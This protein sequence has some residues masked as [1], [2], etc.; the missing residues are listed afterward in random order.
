[1]VIIAVVT[2]ICQD[3]R[4]SAWQ[5]TSCSCR[6]QGQCSCRAGGLYSDIEDSGIFH[7]IF[8]L[9]LRPPSP[10]HQVCRW[11]KKRLW[12]EDASFL[13]LPLAL[14]PVLV[15]RWHTSSLLATFH[16]PSLI[17]WS[18][19]DA[20]ELRNVVSA[21]WL[22]L[23]SNSAER[24]HESLMTNNSAIID[25][26]FEPIT[27][28]TSYQVLWGNTK[29]SYC[30]CSHGGWNIKGNWS[31]QGWEGKGPLFWYVFFPA[32][33]WLCVSIVTGADPSQHLVHWNWPCSCLTFLLNYNIFEVSTSIVLL[34]STEPGPSEE[35]SKCV[36][37][38][39]GGAVR[40][41]A[42]P[43]RK[44]ELQRQ[45][46][47]ILCDFAGVPSLLWASVFHSQ[48]AEKNTNFAGLLW[49]FSEIMNMYS[50]P[51]PVPVWFLGIWRTVSLSSWSTVLAV[52]F[53]QMPFVWSREFPSISSLVSVFVRKRYWILS[54]GFLVSSRDIHIAFVLYA[55]WGVWHI[56][57][58]SGCEI[59][60]VLL[61]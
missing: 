60:F 58:F 15:L 50:A 45:W 31:P 38:R 56:H 36:N 40:C 59:N 30:S 23:C 48:N 28:S 27:C 13:T 26:Y 55:I 44:H 47:L 21:W 17:I 10:V 2:N 43:Y 29:K 9:P 4:G 18:H 52:S 24:K 16:W 19:L 35:I 53:S 6:D 3:F 32:R 39:L 11:K 42:V 25:T 8:Y 57:F 41:S 34:T 51:S 20:R 1:M 7:F 46:N 14:T 49:G 54:E 5:F 22:F 12:K 37:E 61:G 33:P